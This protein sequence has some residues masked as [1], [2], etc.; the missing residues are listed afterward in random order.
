MTAARCSPTT[1]A[2][3]Y[4]TF[5][6]LH[7]THIRYAYAKALGSSLCGL[8][9]L[10]IMPYSGLCSTVAIASQAPLVPLVLDFQIAN[11]TQT[12]Q[13]I[14]Q[15]MLGGTGPP[16]YSGRRSPRSGEMSGCHCARNVIAVRHVSQ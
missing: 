2:L 7:M 13:D 5:P 14:N 10:A 4:N 15:N 6:Q 16:W 1:F 8:E 11:G 3:I 12:P 9:L